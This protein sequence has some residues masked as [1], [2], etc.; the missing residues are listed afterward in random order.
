VSK[1]IGVSSVQTALG[2][3]KRAALAFD[4]IALWNL[5]L[6][7]ENPFAVP[8]SQLAD[9]EWLIDAGIIV[10]PPPPSAEDELLEALLEEARSYYASSN[11][12]RITSE[13]GQFLQRLE[14]YNAKREAPPPEV[15][16]QLVQ[17]LREL[18][19]PANDSS[20]DG[21]LARFISEP[22]G[23]ILPPESPFS[24]VQD[25]ASRVIA[26]DIAARENVDTIPI[27]R[28]LTPKSAIAGGANLEAV[29]TTLV[30]NLPVPD[31]DTPWEAITDFR[32][33]PQSRHKY[34]TL[35]HW[36]HEVANSQM[37]GREL[38]DKLEWLISDYE[39]HMRIHRMKYRRGVLETVVTVAAEILENALKLRLGKL[40]KGIFSYKEQKIA[41]LEAEMK[42]PGREIAYIV[43]AREQ[44]G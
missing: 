44:F 33:D 39:Q 24:V 28:G 14:S 16:A 35:R 36:A 41:L 13:M 37:T 18:G 23:L 22:P 10:E 6:H 32:S 3:L 11:L 40:A 9:L 8:P 2:S 7:R 31:E 25:H 4:Q 29:L 1:L 12:E 42:A 27:L 26:A 30:K 43:T 17:I 21:L 20:D 19:I 38:E 15:Y 34:L 5:K